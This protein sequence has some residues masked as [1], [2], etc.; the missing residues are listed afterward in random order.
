MANPYLILIIMHSVT[1][2][3]DQLLSQRKLEISSDKMNEQT[4]VRKTL[5]SLKTINDQLQFISSVLHDEE[6]ILKKLSISFDL[7]EV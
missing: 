4:E 3:I 5:S 1:T 6:K 2:K 7:K